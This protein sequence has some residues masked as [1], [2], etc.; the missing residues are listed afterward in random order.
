MLYLAGKMDGESEFQSLEIIGI[1]QLANAFVLLVSNLI[2]KGCSI[3]ENRV[4][5][6]RMK[7]LEKLLVLLRQNKR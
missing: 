4:F 5:F 7:L 2:V 6:A 3:L 1:N